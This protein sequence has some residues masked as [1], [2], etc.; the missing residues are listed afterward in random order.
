MLKVIIL[1]RV[2]SIT[3]LGVVMDSR[4]S[5]SRHIDVT[6]GK[7]LAMLRFVKRLSA[8]NLVHGVMRMDG[9]V[10]SSSI[11]DRCTFSRLETLT[12]RLS[13]A[14]VMFVFD[15]LSGKV[16]SLNLLSHFN[17]IAARYRIQ[18]DEHAPLNVAARHFNEVAGL[19]DCHLS[20]F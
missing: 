1:D 4:M 11:V 6:V 19:F 10:W 13:D 3:D 7:A 18:D 8:R 20:I 17:V 2:D 5:F 16:G 14:C 12:R 9:Q 15:V